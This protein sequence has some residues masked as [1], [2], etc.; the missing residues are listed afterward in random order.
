MQEGRY[1][2]EKMIQTLEEN[3]SVKIMRRAIQ[4]EKRE[5]CQLK[6]RIGTIN[7]NR[8]NFI[9][10]VEEFYEALYKNQTFELNE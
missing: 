2:N 4:N 3:Q 5:R 7:S 6:Y 10:I 1:K 8:K 9:T